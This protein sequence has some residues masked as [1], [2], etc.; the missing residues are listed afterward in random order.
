MLWSHYYLFRYAMLSGLNK[1][2]LGLQ[3][4]YDGV[5]MELQGS[6]LG[7]NISVAPSS[8]KL[9]V[10]YQFSLSAHLCRALILLQFLLRFSLLCHPSY[11]YLNPILSFTLWIILIFLS[12]PCLYSDIRTIWLFL[13]SSLL[14][15]F[16]PMFPIIIFRTFSELLFN[17]L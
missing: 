1:V 5:H 10:I 7:F 14:W 8:V 9:G 2:L 15:H 4:K 12:Y 13:L 3:F 11:S 17:K 16:T 6:R